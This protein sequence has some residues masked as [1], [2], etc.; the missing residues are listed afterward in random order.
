MYLV[1]D[2]LFV[3]GICIF[4]SCRFASHFSSIL[5]TSSLHLVTFKFLS[6][7]AGNR[8]FLKSVCCGLSV[9][10]TLPISDSSSDLSKFIIFKNLLFVGLILHSHFYLFVFTFIFLL[11]FIDCIVNFQ[12]FHLLFMLSSLLF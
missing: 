12:V 3:I 1:S 2:R 4:K 5:N 9:F 11:F 10:Q 7:S 6:L 8:F